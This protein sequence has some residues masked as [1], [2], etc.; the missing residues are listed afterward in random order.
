MLAYETAGRGV[1]IVLLH[2]F[3]LSHAMWR[4]QLGSLSRRGRVI[5]PDLPGFGWS[6]RQRE[7]S[8]SRMAEEV[9]ELLDGL[10][11]R[12]PVVVAGLSMG[13]Y[14][15]FECA[16]QF[17]KRLAA[18][19]LVSTRASADPPEIRENRLAMANRIRQE[20]LS[21]LIKTTLPKLVGRTTLESK[22]VVE[23]WLTELI[24]ANDKDGVADALLAMA[25]RRDSSALLTSIACPT[26]VI[27][28]DE[29]AVIPMAETEAMR[30][31]IPVARLE[32]VEGA[33]HLVSLEQ[34]AAFE[35][36]L[37]RF[38]EE[39]RVHPVRAS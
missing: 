28:G 6:V 20:G 4:A 23:R 1:P 15:A 18:L 22:P 33:G 16:R 19:A 12:E 5:A 8:I 31:R 24:L 39:Q 14:V 32:V 17:P 29:D 3:P 27:A 37:E 11:I 13:G 21:P 26:L 2:A 38:L 10:S 34:P 7:P 35:G 30:R 9:A 36:V 25:R